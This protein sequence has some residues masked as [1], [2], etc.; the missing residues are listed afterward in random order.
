MTTLDAR[1]LSCPEPVIRARKAIG[2][3]AAGEQLEILVESV[4]SRENVKRA[5][6]SMS[7]EVEINDQSDGF[8]LIILKP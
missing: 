6:Q 7:C 2:A 4:T 3:M 1:G 5:A 8:R